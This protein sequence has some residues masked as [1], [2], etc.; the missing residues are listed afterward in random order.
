MSELLEENFHSPLLFDIGGCTVNGASPN[1]KEGRIN[2][3]TVGSCSALFL[4]T[5]P[6]LS[7]GAVVVGATYTGSIL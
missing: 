5:P 2:L 7:F 6:E 3:P 1:S 4:T